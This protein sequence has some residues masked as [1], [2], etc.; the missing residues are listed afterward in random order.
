VPAKAGRP[1]HRADLTAESAES[2]AGLTAEHAETAEEKSKLKISA[3]SAHSAVKTLAGAAVKRMSLAPPISPRT[4]AGGKPC[5]QVA[6]LN[7]VSRHQ[8]IR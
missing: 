6:G 8:A 1:A 3:S 5:P 2:T 7:R 4:C